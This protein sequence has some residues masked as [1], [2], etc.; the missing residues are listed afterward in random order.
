MLC[1]CFIG[2]LVA[3]GLSWLAAQLLLLATAGAA[4]QGS[5]GSKASTGDAQ[6]CHDPSLLAVGLIPVSTPMLLLPTEVVPHAQTLA[7]RLPAAHLSAEGRHILKYRYVQATD[8]DS[9]S[10][11]V[12]AMRLQKADLCM[13]AVALQIKYSLFMNGLRQE[14]VQL[15]RKMLSE[16]AIFEPHSFKAMVE[17]VQY[18]RGLGGSR[19]GSS[20]SSSSSS[21]ANRITVGSLEAGSSSKAAGS[22]DNNTA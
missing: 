10:G 2:I 22:I 12:F 16:L 6:L 21:L 18:M 1:P 4:G 19:P 15:N 5:A 17:Q 7:W 13:L 3:A 11:S 20:S 14:N 8:H 9:C